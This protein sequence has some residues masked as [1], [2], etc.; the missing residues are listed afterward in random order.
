M[1]TQFS[2]WLLENSK[3]GE[4]ARRDVVSRLRRADKLVSLPARPDMNYLYDLQQHSEY[5]VLSVSV[6]SQIKKAILLYFDYLRTESS[7]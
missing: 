7:L 3:Y 1:I 6:R 2:Q 4:A 5:K